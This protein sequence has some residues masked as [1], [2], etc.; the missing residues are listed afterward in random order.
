[1]KKERRKTYRERTLELPVVKY[2]LER[3]YFAT[4]G[5]L[6]AIRHFSFVRRGL[7]SP[8]IEVN[9]FKGLEYPSVKVGDT[10]FHGDTM[11]QHVL[12]RLKSF[13]KGDGDG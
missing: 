11:G 4:A 7:G 1:M 10:S 12:E 2:A 5:N 6:F 13:G 8:V 9:W 3:G